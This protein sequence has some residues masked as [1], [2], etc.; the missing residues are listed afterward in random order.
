GGAAGGRDRP[1]RRR[2][3][4]VVARRA[5]RLRTT[6]V[7]AGRQPRPALRPPA[8]RLRSPPAGATPLRGAFLDGPAWIRTS[9]QINTFYLPR[10]APVGA[11]L[12]HER[13]FLTPCARPTWCGRTSIAPRAAPGKPSE[14]TLAQANE[15]PQLAP[16]RRE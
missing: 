14:R 12:E 11:R 8:L 15:P 9:L 10:G 6:R 1:G 2:A 16:S 5:A 7:P 3:G 4:V 13:L